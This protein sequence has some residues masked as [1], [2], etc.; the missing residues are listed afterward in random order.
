MK[1]REIINEP[2][3]DHPSV[4]IGVLVAI[5]AIIL[6]FLTILMII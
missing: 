6:I 3:I 5:A 4:M 2:I 1:I